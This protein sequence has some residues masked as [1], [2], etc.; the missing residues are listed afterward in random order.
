LKA[1][2]PQIT[3]SL[4]SQI[5]NQGV[6]NLSGEDLTSIEM[7]VLAVGVGF[8]PT[9]SINQ[10]EFK[11]DLA[12]LAWRMKTQVCALTFEE[13]SKPETSVVR[14]PSRFEP[15]QY[16][17]WIK[18]DIQI[19]DAKRECLQLIA[20][21]SNQMDEIWKTEDKLQFNLSKEE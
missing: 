9:S 12:K 7:R 21:F 3:G 14:L 11:K 19:R 20:E 1:S 4:A 17:P 5:D 2:S 18:N 10:D 6:I 15:D 8:I 16:Q 13:K